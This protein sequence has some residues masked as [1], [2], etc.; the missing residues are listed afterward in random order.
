MPGQVADHVLD[1]RSVQDREHL[2]RGVGGEWSEPGAEPADQDDG[3]H[4]VAGAVVG[5]VAGS[6]A[7]AAGSVAAGA[8]VGALGSTGAPGTVLSAGTSPPGGS[9]PSGSTSPPGGISPVA[10]SAPALQA[11]DSSPSATAFSQISCASGGAGTSV[12]FGTKAMVYAPRSSVNRTSPKP[13]SITS[14]A[15]FAVGAVRA[16]FQWTMRTSAALPSH[17]VSPAL[18][19]RPSGSLMRLSDTSR[20]VWS[21]NTLILAF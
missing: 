15:F 5:A 18:N 21:K 6:D 3:P 20:P 1:H 14:S 17:F 11:P 12:P 13:S 16:S 10:D 19:V 2:L 4:P 8:L 9:S 7:G